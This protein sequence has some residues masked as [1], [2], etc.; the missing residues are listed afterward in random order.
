MWEDVWFAEL[1]YPSEATGKKKGIFIG[2]SSNNIQ[3]NQDITSKTV[4]SVFLYGLD[5]STV[6]AQISNKHT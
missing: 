3:E 1:E 6:Q 4:L 5:H 2:T